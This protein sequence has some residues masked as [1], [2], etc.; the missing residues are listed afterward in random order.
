M[1][2]LEIKSFHF[3]DVMML[4]MRKLYLEQSIFTIKECFREIACR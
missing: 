1:F 2:S 3:R 4:E